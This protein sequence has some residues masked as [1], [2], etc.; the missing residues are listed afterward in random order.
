VNQVRAERVANGSRRK[1]D[2]ATVP[3]G[4]QVAPTRDEAEAWIAT[5]LPG[6][7][8]H[9]VSAARFHL[10]KQGQPVNAATIREFLRGRGWLKEQN[11]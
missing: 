5:N 10:R 7:S 9:V 6:E 3:T 4:N 8:F 1:R 11:S 2:L